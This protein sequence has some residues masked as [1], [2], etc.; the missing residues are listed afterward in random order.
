MKYDITQI[1]LTRPSEAKSNGDAKGMIFACRATLPSGYKP[2][3]AT[4]G[5]AGVAQVHSTQIV[6]EAGVKSVNI[7]PAIYDRIIV[8]RKRAEIVYS[9]STVIAY[10]L[11]TLNIPDNYLPVSSVSTFFVI[12]ATS[13][14]DTHLKQIIQGGTFQTHNVRQH[15]GQHTTEFNS[16]VGYLAVKEVA[17]EPREVSCCDQSLGLIKMIVSFT[18]VVVSL[19][20]RTSITSHE[21]QLFGLFNAGLIAAEYDLSLDLMI[22]AGLISYIAGSKI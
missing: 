19:K 1:T 6:S 10:N 4:G 14:T 22:T 21:T 2:V 9:D 3:E 20:D 5:I 13:M 17:S 12:H 16:T 11:S 8:T 7:D 15:S 18:S